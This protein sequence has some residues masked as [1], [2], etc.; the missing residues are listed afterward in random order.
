MLM[1]V[2]VLLLSVTCVVEAGDGISIKFEERQRA[3]VA[4]L[5]DETQENANGKGGKKIAPAISNGKGVNDTTASNV[6]VSKPRETEKV[7]D[8]K[9]YFVLT[10]LKGLKSQVLACWRTV[11][12]RLEKQ[13]YL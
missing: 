5:D 7:E 2:L 4:A 12:K 1:S 9:H 6:N 11:A 3:E 13:A 8:G 10:I